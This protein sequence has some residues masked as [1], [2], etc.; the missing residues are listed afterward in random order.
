M[1]LLFFRDM[2]TDLAV[3]GQGVVCPA[4]IGMAAL[5]H[6]HPSET[7]SPFVSRPDHHWPTF[8]VNLN[9]P[10]L[11]RWQK[12]PR[13][14]R[15]SPIGYFLVEAAEQALMGSSAAHR[16]QTGLVVAF[17]TGCLDYSRRFFESIVAEGQKSASPMLF[18][19]TVFNS[20]VSHVASVLN[21]EG[22]AYVLVG[23]ETAWIGALKTAW[24]WL[25]QERV[26][27]VLVLGAEEF[28]SASL[29]ACHSAGWLKHRDD[30]PA[31]I[32]SEGAAGVLVRRTQPGDANIIS[33]MEDGFIYRSKTEA[34]S[35][36]QRCFQQFDSSLPCAENPQRHWL[37]DVERRLL[38]ARCRKLN[39]HAYLGEATTAS[40]AW[41]TLRALALLG[42]SETRL[43]IPISGKTHQI[44]ALQIERK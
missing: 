11:Q 8:R 7:M 2:K 6:A 25:E 20:P 33:Q 32:P 40:A 41:N 37:G 19:E 43:L 15:A 14:R 17:S 27:Q 34:R 29:D 12:Q 22:S 1:Q 38:Q 26:E 3:I 31:F 36:A 13:L 39:K 44:A 10:S 24:L 21:L 35:A 16:A 23:D 28:E 42:Q 18:P 30:K 4:G 5:L 9:D